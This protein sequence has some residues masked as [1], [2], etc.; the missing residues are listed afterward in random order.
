ME[1]KTFLFVLWEGGGNVPP[2]LGLARQMVRRGHRSIVISDPCNEP[3]ARAA[4]C[5]FFPYTT[6]PRRNDKSADS[7]ILNDY[8]AAS[9]I[10]GFKIFLDRIACGP[11]LP[12]A[13]D[14]LRLLDTVK[15]DVV[16]VSEVLFGGC[17]AAE[18][19]QLPCVMAIPGTCSLPAPGMPPPGMLPQPGL[20]GKLFDKVS[21]IVFKKL[22]ASRLPAFNQ[23][24]TALGLPPVTDII[25]YTYSFPRRILLMTS[26]DFEFPARFPDTVRVTGAVLD[27]PFVNEADSVSLSETDKRKL[28][29]VSFSSTYQNQAETLQKVIA[30]AG[31]L[32]YRTLI[33]LGP[34]MK[35]EMKNIPENVAIQSFLP[36]SQVLPQCAAVVT[37]AGHGTVVRSLAFGVPLVCIPMGRDQAANAARV[38]Y[39]KLG[40]RLNK[41]AG[42][43]KIANAIRTVV[44]HPE[45]RENARRLSI[46]LKEQ[47]RWST[48]CEEL[49]KAVR[50]P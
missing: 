15:V 1:P 3:E 6:A 14:V 21:S 50:E 49:E 10:R 13:Q 46:K 33:T 9:T 18:V 5:D 44:E 45:Y 12:Y 23:A 31:R 37:H 43:K 20:V 40:A 42:V 38:I 25:E 48:A 16:V 30:A 24:R 11:A 27:D 7:T 8:E 41:R 17:F 29:L 4:G 34:A 35:N 36:H 47:S 26:P 28:I 2:I 32:P 39:R 22:T 19:K